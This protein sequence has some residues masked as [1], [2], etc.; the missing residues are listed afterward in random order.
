MKPRFTPSRLRCN[1]ITWACSGL[2]SGTIIGTS[3]VARWAELLE[4]T[5]V[6]ARA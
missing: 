1:S 5:G 2:S 4:I 3:G 6:S